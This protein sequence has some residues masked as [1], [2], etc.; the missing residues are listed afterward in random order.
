MAWYNSNFAEG[1]GLGLLALGLGGGFYLCNEAEDDNRPQGC[2]RDEP[3]ITQ[4]HILGHDQPEVYITQ[5][6]TPYFSHI[7]GK[8]VDDFVRECYQP[9][10][11]PPEIEPMMP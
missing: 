6:G 4:Q 7:D 5:D 11:R 1:L 9:E 8:S 2:S 3:A 10:E